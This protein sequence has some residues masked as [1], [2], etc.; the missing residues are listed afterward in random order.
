MIVA[1][2]ALDDPL[3]RLIRVRLPVRQN[4]D[5]SKISAW[6]ADAR[7][8]GYAVM[9]ETPGYGDAPRHPVHP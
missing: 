9:G 5:M 2:D 7:T 8:G 1:I 3:A 4:N 6:V